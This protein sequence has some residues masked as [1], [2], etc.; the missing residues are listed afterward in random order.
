M[1][2]SRLTAIML[3]GFAALLL[4]SCAAPEK[5]SAPPAPA[6]APQP[7]APP[8][9]VVPF[10]PSPEPFPTPPP[11]PAAPPVVAAPPVANTADLAPDII[12]WESVD[13]SVTVNFGEPVA[14]F[15]FSLTNLSAAPV[16]VIAVPAS[17][18]C[19][20][21]QVPPL[22]W[23]IAPGEKA[24]FA[25]NMN[26]AGKGGTVIKTV[27]FTTDKGTKHLLVRTTIVPQPTPTAMAPGSREQNQL[28]A[29]S[30]RQAIFK[31]DCVSC[32]VEKAK[33]KQDYEL[34][35]AACGICHDAEHRA[36]MVPD[37]RIAKAGRDA[38]YWQNW[39]SLGRLGSLMPAFAQSA[40]G[41]FTDE[42][43]KSLVT[44]LAGH[45]PQTNAVVMH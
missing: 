1:K 24:S 37:L 11:A 22:P 19:T 32:H 36:T 18:G 9:A 4:A 28:L 26:L 25:V 38:A 20:T 40:G 29:L 12:A 6:A 45:P 15:Q 33:G 16:T 43:I 7:V 31:G 13:K 21:A 34:Y 10:T 27:S 42:Q 44:Y 23:I 41:P 17:C 3:T 5:K 2:A 39:I 14:K 8:V 30:D 35:V